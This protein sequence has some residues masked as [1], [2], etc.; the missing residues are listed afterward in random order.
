MKYGNTVFVALLPSGREGGV[1]EFNGLQ[2]AFENR[3]EVV[4]KWLI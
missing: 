1:V 4:D 2:A 3:A